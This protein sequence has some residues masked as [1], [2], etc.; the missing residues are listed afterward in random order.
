VISQLT[1]V[2]LGLLGGSVAKAARARQLARTI[3][4]VG[5]NLKSMQAALSDAGTI[6]H[7]TTDVSAGVA[8]ADWVVLATPV[9]TLETVLREVWPRLPAEATITD[10]GSA[11]AAIVR[12][13]ERLCAARPRAFVG[14]HPMAGS[15]RSGYA[16]ARPDLFEGAMVVVTP[17]EWS[18]PDAVKR[19]IGFWERL[20][21]RVTT[22]DPEVH[23][24]Q[25]ALVSHLPHLVACALVD[26][27]GRGDTASLQIA[28]RGFKD[29]TRI[30][31]SAPPVWREIFLT[32]RRALEAAL[33]HFRTALTDLESLVARGDAAA[34]DRRLAEIKAMRDGLA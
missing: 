23:D 11:K 24:A 32:N 22:L 16:A 13:A 3:V 34:L 4:A 8:T 18:A 25:A 15:E 28:G 2:G 17:T 26:A 30:A 1:V 7:V 9:A 29:S 10:V 21:A 12:T 33:A 20:G 14:S 6:D 31:A 5:R 19:V 27:V